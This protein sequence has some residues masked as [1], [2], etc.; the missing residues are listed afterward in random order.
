MTGNESLRMKG[1]ADQVGS[2]AKQVVEKGK[3]AGKN[4]FGR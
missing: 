2:D 1:K 4:A 3:D